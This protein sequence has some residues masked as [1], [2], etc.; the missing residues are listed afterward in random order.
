LLIVR[1]PLRISLAGGGSD[2]PA[3]YREYG[4][5]VINMA[6]DRY[7]YVFLRTSSKQSEVQIASADLQTFDS[8]KNGLWQGGLELPQAIFRHF[9]IEEGVSLFLA[10]EVPP[11]TGLGSSS[12]VAVGLIKALATAGGLKITKQEIA[13]L[14]SY[15]EIEVLNSPIGKQ[16]QYAA[17]FGGINLIQFE[18]QETTIAPFLLPTETVLS[19]SE[20]LLL[21]YTGRQR[22][23]NAILSQQREATES[24][25][26]KVLEALHR[27]KE[28]VQSVKVTLERG[29]MEG[30]GELLHQNWMEKKRFAKGVTNQFIDD[31]YDLARR[32]GAWG[33]KITGAGGGGFL[34]LCCPGARQ[35]AVTRA[36]ETQH[37]IRISFA[38]DHSGARVLMN[39]GLRLTSR[40]SWTPPRDLLRSI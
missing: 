18:A 11:G 7:F 35:E 36:L 40:L 37:L 5:K 39:S 22:K 20:S 31:L 27:V 1:S 3:Y 16:D 6:I 15:I 21:F 13:E 10:S 14:A 29:D 38:I 28:M 26:G 19:L 12:T 17:A 2:L 8:L 30:L 24:R 4:G 34:L 32:E 25:K 23:A 9:G 33:G